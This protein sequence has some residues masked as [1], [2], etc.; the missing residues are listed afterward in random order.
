MH[1]MYSMLYTANF[2][3]VRLCPVFADS[4]TN[5]TLSLVS[6][7]LLLGLLCHNLQCGFF[8]LLQHIAICVTVLLEF[9]VVALIE[10]SHI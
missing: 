3:L 7:L 8:L 1:P 5:G 2:K 6:V 4:V 10:Q 9:T